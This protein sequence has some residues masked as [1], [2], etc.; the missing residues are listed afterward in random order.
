MK[1]LIALLPCILC[2]GCIKHV[3]R[4]EHVVHFDRTLAQF[5]LE[6]YQ[7]EDKLRLSSFGGRAQRNIGAFF[8][9]FH[10]LRKSPVSVDEARILIIKY[11]E[12][13]LARINS[14][15]A[16]RPFLDHY[17]MGVNDIKLSIGF[18][19]KKQH[20]YNDG[21][22][23]YVLIFNKNVIY[24]RKNPKNGDFED[25]QQETYEEA[26]NIVKDKNFGNMSKKN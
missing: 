2:S 24:C 21:S 3:N 4:P 19:D 6:A 5:S 11:A 7:Q 8:L 23:A 14:D 16:M 13:L 18:Y 1:F 15:G 25:L 26:L 9:G 12:K 17:P 20:Q 10:A 22:V